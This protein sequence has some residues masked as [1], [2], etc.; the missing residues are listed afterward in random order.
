MI[1]RILVNNKVN[2]VIL[3][4]KNIKFEFILSDHSLKYCSCKNFYVNLSVAY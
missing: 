2:A 4:K 3:K 1:M